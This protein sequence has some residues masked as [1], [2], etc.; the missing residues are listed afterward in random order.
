MAHLSEQIQPV[1][2]AINA[3]SSYT[4]AASSSIDL[5]AYNADSCLIVATIHDTTTTGFTMTATVGAS[6]AA[7]TTAL[8][9]SGS[10]VALTV[11]TTAPA[12]VCWI[13]LKNLPYRYVGANHTGLA[14][15]IVSILGFPYNSKKQPI[16]ITSSVGSTVAGSSNFAVS[17]NPSTT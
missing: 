11:G 2:M 5:Q 3:G 9:G 14:A 17:V 7:M 15:S 4:V 1:L 13:D 10:T 12:K 16:P 6:T 8:T